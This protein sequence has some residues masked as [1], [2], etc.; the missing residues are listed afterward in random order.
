M[1]IRKTIL[2]VLKVA[3]DVYTVYLMVERVCVLIMGWL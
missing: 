2:D 1:D 3:A